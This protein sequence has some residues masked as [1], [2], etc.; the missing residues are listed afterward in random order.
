MARNLPYN[1]PAATI[2]YFLKTMSLYPTKFQT[3]DARVA[4]IFATFF[5]TSG[6]P[7]AVAESDRTEE[8]TATQTALIPNPMRLT[9]KNK[10]K[11][12]WPWAPVA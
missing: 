5:R 2:S 9:T 11:L 7:I 3:N 10:A 12:D 8:N 4:I 1:G 6:L